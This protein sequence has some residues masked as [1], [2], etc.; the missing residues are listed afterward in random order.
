VDGSH[1]ICDLGTF[2]TRRSSDLTTG[3][4]AWSVVSGGTGSFSPNA[5]TPNATFTHATG[6]GPIVVRWAISNSP[7][8][9]STANVTITIN[10]PT[11]TA[12]TSELQTPCTLVTRPLL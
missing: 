12:K 1:T 7:C 4:G 10:Q 6:T 9:A 11:S 8:A 2:P 5:T 3:T